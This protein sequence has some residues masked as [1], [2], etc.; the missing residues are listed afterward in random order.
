MEMN[1]AVLCIVDV[2]DIFSC[3]MEVY[4]YPTWRF[5]DNSSSASC[6]SAINLHR[7]TSSM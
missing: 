2:V 1:V 5:F 4:V 7:R 3:W 6:L